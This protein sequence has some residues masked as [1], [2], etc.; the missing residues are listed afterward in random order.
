MTRW[1][2]HVDLDQFLASVELRRHP[3]LVGLPVIVGGSG[4]PTEPRKVV[5]CASYEAREFG[6]HAGMPLRAAARRCPDATFLASDPA[7]YDEASEQVMGLLRDLGHPVE[8]WGWDEA[9][10]AAPG[11]PVNVAETIRSVVAAET[12]LSCSVGISDNKQRAKVATGFAKPAG[13]FQLTDANWMALMADRPV[14]A[15]WGIGPKTAKRLAALDIST[16]GQLARTDGELLTSTFGPRT[17][18]WLLLLAKGGG[19]T[20]VSSQPWV[21]RS[22][23][24]AVTFPRDLTDRA[25]MDSAV[26]EL[27]QRALDDVVASERIV[28][29]VAVTVRTATFYT[30]TK[31]RK[32][33]APTIDSDV[34]AAAALRILD[35][36]ELDRPIRLLGVRLELEMP[37]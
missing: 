36:F 18:L 6:V 34:I 3:E 13:V 26:T 15:L 20:E 11:D 2:L 8:V 7:A 16:V 32:L 19:D 1:V 28:T 17:G 27:A 33:N 23:S 14:D 5:T 21:P 4:D 35:L 31:I 29:R 30:R 22:R 12:G 37:S 24:H 9:Y 10:V 25:E